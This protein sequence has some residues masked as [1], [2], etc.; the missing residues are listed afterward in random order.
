ML[1]APDGGFS[2]L[3]LTKCL[4]TQCLTHT[5]LSVICSHDDSVWRERRNPRVL[6][7]HS[8]LSS[9]KTITCAG[10]Y[11]VLILGAQFLKLILSTLVPKR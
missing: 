2:E 5:R 9:V 4:L 10:D 7:N 3:V 8:D 11:C 1:L 6:I